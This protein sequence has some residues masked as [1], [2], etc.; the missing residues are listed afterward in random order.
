MCKHKNYTKT[1]VTI[2]YHDPRSA[3]GH[4]EMSSY[5]YIC[6][7]C[8][9]DITEMVLNPVSNCCGSSVDEWGFCSKCKENC[10]VEIMEE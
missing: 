7:D 8:G 6:D 3:D 1:G 2:D 10:E 5:A 4:G 9:R